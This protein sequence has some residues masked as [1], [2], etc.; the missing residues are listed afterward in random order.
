[1]REQ[2][3]QWIDYQLFEWVFWRAFRFEEGGRGEG[4][5]QED[6]EEGF[7]LKPKAHVLIMLDKRADAKGE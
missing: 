6:Q 3:P 4:L 1:M 5:A 2:V 7:D